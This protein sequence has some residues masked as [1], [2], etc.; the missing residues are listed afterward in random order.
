MS[1]YRKRH[2][3]ERQRRCTAPPSL[4]TV[5]LRRSRCQIGDRRS[6]GRWPGISD[7]V[8]TAP[9]SR[10]GNEVAALAIQ[11]PSVRRKRQCYPKEVVDRVRISLATIPP[12][13]TPMQDNRRKTILFVVIASRPAA[14]GRGLIDGAGIAKD[15]A[16]GDHRQNHAGDL[17]A[18]GSLSR[19]MLGRSTCRPTTRACR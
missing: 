4:R 16:H 8:Y 11:S 1:G 10:S 15:R 5:R 3:H 6:D 17:D 7:G 14:S 19:N 13:L 18:R 12:P 2:C 9:P